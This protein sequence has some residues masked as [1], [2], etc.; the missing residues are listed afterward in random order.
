MGCAG[1]DSNIASH[2]VAHR[3]W[4]AINKHNRSLDSPE[5][6]MDAPS[7]AGIAGLDRAE[8]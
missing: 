6:V 5:V 4:Y 7:P 2:G 3:E 8:K 1:R